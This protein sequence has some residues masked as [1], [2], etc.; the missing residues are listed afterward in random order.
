M[1]IRWISVRAKPMAM[2]AKPAGARW[3]VAP[4]MMIRKNMVITTLV[5]KALAH[6]QTDRAAGDQV[7]NTTGHNATQ[8]LHHAE[9]QA[10]IGRETATRPQADGDSRIQATTRNLTHG[11]GHGQHRQAK[12]QR[13]T[14][15]T[16]AHLR[17]YSG[18]NSAA[19]TTQHQPG[20]AEL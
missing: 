3:S 4:M 14:V 12:G 5:S 18:Q 8:N 2:G 19:A 17:K 10:L 1:L 16:N 9:G 11:K 7:Q 15:Q 6:I 20:P 13:H